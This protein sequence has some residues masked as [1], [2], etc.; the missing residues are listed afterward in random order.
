MI[1]GHNNELFETKRSENIVS[2]CDHCF[3]AAVE[4]GEVHQTNGGASSIV[5]LITASTRPADAASSAGTRSNSR[6]GDLDTCWQ[7][8][9]KVLKRSR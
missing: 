9:V 4:D 5:K 3:L 6:A 2:L 8:F 1:N 7:T